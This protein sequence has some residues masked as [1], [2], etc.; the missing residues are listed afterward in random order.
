[1]S[2]LKLSS[3]KLSSVKN[4]LLSSDEHIVQIGCGVVGGAYAKAYKH[5]GFKLTGLD[6]VPSII[7]KMNKAGIPCY[8]PN[9]LPKDLNADILLLS[10]PSPLDQ[11]KQRLSMKY[12]WS[13]LKTTAQLIEQS[14]GK[15]IIVVIRSTAPPG[16]TEEYEKRLKE[17]TDK[18]FHIA[19]Q[20]EFLRAVS[21]EE[22]ALK[23]WKVIFGY[24]KG[25]DKQIE[26]RLSKVFLKFV[27]GRKD[28]L[29]ILTLQEAEFFKLI[30]NY[31]NA[32]RISFANCMYGIG[33]HINPEIDVQKLLYLVTETA[34]NFLSKKYG[35]RVGAPYGGTCLPKDTP[36]MA[37]VAPEGP[38]K[39]FVNATTNINSWITEHKELQRKLEISPNWVDHEYL[40][41]QAKQ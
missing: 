34:E 41:K 33:Q 26:E 6:V 2:S 39:D 17:L 23:P 21:C 13:T 30:H 1:M 32:L 9:D 16:L 10:V 19:F 3:V 28:L 40:K 5:Y 35:L 22:D 29:Q 38:L 15:D 36:E 31:S 20:P 14:K 12:L 18:K 25:D 4:L 24:R 7:Q 8:H 37:G 27:N 11:E